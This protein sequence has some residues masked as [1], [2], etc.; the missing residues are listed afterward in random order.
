MCL[1]GHGFLCLVFWEN[2]S[3]KREEIAGNH[4]LIII[5]LLQHGQWGDT[6][7]LHPR[8]TTNRG[9]PPAP[10]KP[11]FETKKNNVCSTSKSGGH[12]KDLHTS[13]LGPWSVDLKETLPMDRVAFC[14]LDLTKKSVPA[15]VPKRQT[16]QCFIESF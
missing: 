12:G 11:C 14:V 10:K 6:Q 16:C 9:I 4:W 2:S 1:G 15:L 8:L 13:I 5:F 3:E 7:M